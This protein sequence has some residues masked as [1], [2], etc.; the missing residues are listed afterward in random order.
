MRISD[1]SSDVC[2]SD[3]SWF[4]ALLQQFKIAFLAH[5]GAAQSKNAAVLVQSARPV[6]LVERG[7]ELAQRQVAGASEKDDV[8][9]GGSG[10]GRFLL[11]HSAAVRS[12][13]GITQ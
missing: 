3:L 7:Y 9:G 12:V 11:N 2:S 13:A 1:W 4:D 8:K 5:G 10:H 6:G